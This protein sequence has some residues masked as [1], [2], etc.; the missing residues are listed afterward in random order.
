M[1]I[2]HQAKIKIIIFLITSLRN[3]DYHNYKKNKTK[4]AYGQH[5]AIS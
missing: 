2:Q 3:Y 1:A 4:L 5:L